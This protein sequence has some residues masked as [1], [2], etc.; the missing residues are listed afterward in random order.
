MI[1]IVQLEETEAKG[2]LV[3]RNGYTKVESKWRVKI[4]K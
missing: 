2:D 4:Q 3:R 1:A